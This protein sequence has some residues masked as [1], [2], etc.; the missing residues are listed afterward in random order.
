[1]VLSVSRYWARH[2]LLGVAQI[3]GLILDAQMCIGCCAAFRC[4]KQSTVT[5]S[6]GRPSA[7]PYLHC[8]NCFLKQDYAALVCSH[9]YSEHPHH[10]GRIDSSLMSI[11]M[12]L[13][14]GCSVGLSAHPRSL[15]SVQEC[16]TAMQRQQ[17]SATDA[18]MR[19]PHSFLHHKCGEAVLT[20][21]EIQCS[22]PVKI[23]WLGPLVVPAPGGSAAEAPGLYVALQ[24]K[25]R[26]VK[27]ER[28]SR[29]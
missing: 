2:A 29:D 20:Q 18:N 4:R 27:H 14:N 10:F 5:S 12:V 15:L 11:N 25:P 26:P 8:Q 16:L 7:K 17:W 22:L 23:L 9:F 1:M 19:P 28:W 13:L 3:L 6:V 21:H 24:S